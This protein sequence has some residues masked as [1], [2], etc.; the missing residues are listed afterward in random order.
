MVGHSEAVWVELKSP[1][2]EDEAR[3][4]LAQAPSL[5]VVDFPTP[6]EAAGIDEVLVGRIRRDPTTENGLVLFLSSDNLRKGAALNAIQIVELI[7]EHSLRGGPSP[8]RRK[9]HGRMTR[10]S[11]ISDRAPSPR[12]R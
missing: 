9:S 12:P 4:V 3:E 11:A 8:P 1:F 6:R 5:R 2:S 7:V 10:T